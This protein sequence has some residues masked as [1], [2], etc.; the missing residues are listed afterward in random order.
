MVDLGLNGKYAVITGGTHGIGKSIALSL[1]DEGCNV[2]VFS[3]TQERVNE[4]AL[5]LKNKNVDY[6]CEQVDVFVEEKVKMIMEMIDKKWGRTDILINNVGGGGR[7]GSD[8]IEDTPDNVWNEVYY[9]NSVIAFQFIKWTIPYMRKNK[10]G[11]VISISSVYGKEAGGRPWFN[12]AK[13]AQ[14]SLMKTLSKTHYLVKDGI[15][16][17]TIAPGPIFIQDTGWDKKDPDKKEQC[18]KIENEIPLGRMG[19]SEEISFVAKFM[20]SPLNSFMNGS[21]IVLDGGFSYS[22]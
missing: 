9:K 19:T 20:C 6:I 5:C 13:S 12:M 7:W 2:A 10:W 16:F 17:N 1:A 3:R 14:I 15:T 8:I 22:F 11:R 4:M 21:C 18:D